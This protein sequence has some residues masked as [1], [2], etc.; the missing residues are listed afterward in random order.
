MKLSFNHATVIV[1]ISSSLLLAVTSCKK[2]S[3]GSS[4]TSLSATVGTTA[5]AGNSTTAGIYVNA[6][7]EFEIGST[8]LKTGDTTA[9]LL[10]F[11][12]PFTLGRA[13]NSD[14]IGVDVNYV[15]SKTSNL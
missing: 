11:N 1:L 10:Y 12:T 15:D 13:M 14:T 2:S 3:S 5:W 9:F 4:G 8:Q 7:T 6:L